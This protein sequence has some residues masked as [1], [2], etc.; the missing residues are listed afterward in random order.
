MLS[1]LLNCPPTERRLFRMAAIFFFFFSKEGSN[2][3][4]V[5]TVFKCGP[6]RKIN[7]SSIHGNLPLCWNNSSCWAPYLVTFTICILA[8]NIMSVCCVERGLLQTKPFKQLDHL[9]AY[10]YLYSCFLSDKIADIF[11]FFPRRLTTYDC[12]ILEFFF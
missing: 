4:S 7:L 2:H 9:K 3:T 8:K 1:R 10:I 12:L 6:D 11:F 5:L